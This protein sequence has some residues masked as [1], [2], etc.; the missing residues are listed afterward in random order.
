MS[1]ICELR[2]DYPVYASPIEGVV[3]IPGENLYRHC[4]ERDPNVKPLIIYPPL[5]NIWIPVD[6][7]LHSLGLATVSDLKILAGDTNAAVVPP[8]ITEKTKSL[9]VRDSPEM[10][11]FPL[12]ATI[13]YLEESLIEFERLREIPGF[14][15]YPLIFGHES[16]GTC[17]ERVYNRIQEAR[18]QDFTQKSFGHAD[19]DF[20]AVRDS[21]RGIYEFVGFLLKQTG[22]W[23]EGNV[24]YNLKRGHEM[25]SL[26]NEGMACFKMAEEFERD[27]RY[28]QSLVASDEYSKQS[29]AFYEDSR[30]LQ[31]AR[32]V[33][34]SSDPLPQKKAK[35]AKFR[36]TLRRLTKS[37]MKRNQPRGVI[38]T[39]GEI[40]HNE[41]METVSADIGI[42]LVSRGYF[43]EKHSG[44]GRYID[45]FDFSLRNLAGL[46]IN[47]MVRYCNPFYEDERRQLAAR[48]G[49]THDVGGHSLDIVALVQQVKEQQRKGIRIDGIIELLPFGCLPEVVIASVMDL[50]GVKYLRLMFD[51]LSGKA[52]VITRLEAYLDMIARLQIRSQRA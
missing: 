28:S 48:G 20:Y 49:L 16:T 46:I 12:K 51:E 13:G 30:I 6:Y 24:S 35:I 14:H 22:N 33:L 5:G 17:R 29:P 52:G 8:R 23:K 41:E 15:Y 26:I 44:I 47:Y 37:N 4:K 50:S 40:F 11:C 18:L 21:I 2:A 39:T 19:F 3:Y 34:A 1:A 31:Q 42:E 45:K 43:F 36:D 32:I 25:I 10:V 38:A 27:V 9:G 7:I